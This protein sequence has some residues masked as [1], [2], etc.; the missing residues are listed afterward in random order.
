MVIDCS[1]I[2]AVLCDIQILTAVLTAII[3]GLLKKRFRGYYNSGSFFRLR[4]FQNKGKVCIVSL[5][6]ISLRT[7]SCRE[8]K[9]L[10][11]GYQSVR[12]RDLITMY[13]N[14][15][16]GLMKAVVRRGVRLR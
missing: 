1:Q 14:S 5:Q 13:G 2:T 11:A 9:K 6:A 3:V 16:K 10:F 7:G 15:K 12:L 4:V 8:R